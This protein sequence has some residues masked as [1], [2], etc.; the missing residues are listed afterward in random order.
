MNAFYELI[1]STSAKLERI[2]L[3]KAL[4]KDKIYYYDVKEDGITYNYITKF[5]NIGRF[6]YISR[7]TRAFSFEGP[8]VQI[9]RK[10]PEI[11]SVFAKAFEIGIKMAP[12]EV[13]EDGTFWIVLESGKTPFE[14]AKEL[15]DMGITIYGYDTKYKTFFSTNCFGRPF[16]YADDMDIA[17]I[18]I[19]VSWYFYLRKFVHKP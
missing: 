11:Y 10:L 18:E 17:P 6:C 7:T 12:I 14:Y 5:G 19:A 13:T 15:T 4:E 3:Y 1:A 9:V 8:G 16:V 2:T